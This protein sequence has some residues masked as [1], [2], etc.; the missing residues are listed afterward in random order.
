VLL[1][2]KTRV[3]LSAAVPIF[4]KCTDYQVN[5]NAKTGIAN[6]VDSKE[7]VIA[8][9]PIPKLAANNIRL[10]FDDYA[11]TTYV[12][13]SK[14]VGTSKVLVLSSQPDLTPTVTLSSSAQAVN[15]G[16]AVTY[17]ATLDK[18]SATDLN[19]PYTL[20]GNATLTADYTGSVATTGT[21][22]IAKGSKTGTL[23]LKAVSDVTTESVAETVTVTLGAVANVKLGVVTQS[24][25]ITDTSLTPTVPVNTAPINISATLLTATATTGVDE[26]NIASGNYA[27]TIAGFN[28]GDKL[29]LF[30]G[31]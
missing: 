9:L 14:P 16:S 1:P 29:G 17:T 3:V 15:E 11:D 2:K 24:T 7:T 30:A 20:G 4:D 8:S 5:Y 26:F 23:V 25:T 10:N 6:V 28:N 18:V 13:L 19:I 27:A 31:R 12:T 21:I 22:T